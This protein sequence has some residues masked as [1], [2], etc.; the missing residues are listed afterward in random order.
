MAKNN[1]KEIYFT[2]NITFP[3]NQSNSHAVCACHYE[4]SHLK[5]HKPK[6]I[7]VFYGKR[8]IFPLMKSLR[9][10]KKKLNSLS[11]LCLEVVGKVVLINFQVSK[12]LCSNSC[13]VFA[14][15]QVPVQNTPQGLMDTARRDTW[16]S[17]YE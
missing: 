13:Y 2:G 5:I 12:D 7:Q 6:V 11:V 14:I 9:L 8:C 10:P 16:R 1:G 17:C 15:G 4:N 3:R